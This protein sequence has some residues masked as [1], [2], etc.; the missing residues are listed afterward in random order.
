MRTRPS[1]ISIA[2][3]GASLT[4]AVI[5]RGEDVIYAFTGTGDHGSLA[6]GR[7]TTPL[8]TQSNYYA[9]G[10]GYSSFS[11]SVSNIPGSGSGTG[12]NVLIFHKS[13]LEIYSVFGT[14][15]NGV[16]YILPL[17]DY[18]LGPPEHNLYR[19]SGG[20]EGNQSA[21]TYNNT[22]RDYITWSGLTI[23]S[24]PSPPVLSV[25]SSAN[26]VINLS[27]T[28][29]AMD[30]V[31]EETTNLA[32]PIWT[33]VTNAPVTAGGK[34]LVMLPCTDDVHFFRLEWP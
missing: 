10:G 28:T 13:D 24:P 9:P 11:L 26:G 4:L 30:F 29:N 19:L 33:V 2:L 3:I 21:L 23:I 6:W 31:L 27:W 5:A 22:F 7:F 32:P 16:P 8:V 18:D 1:G 34:F 15:S 12:T 20:I 25:E 14:D 17:G